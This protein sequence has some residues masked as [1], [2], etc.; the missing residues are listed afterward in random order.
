M[1]GNV[2]EHP[3]GLIA[4]A[5]LLLVVLLYGL[6][7]LVRAMQ[8]KRY[9]TRSRAP[10]ALRDR[11]VAWRLNPAY[12]RI[13][14][15]HN[16]QGFRHSTNVSLVKPPGTVRIFLLGGSAAYGAQGGFTHLENR[17]TRIYNH[18][19]IDAFLEQKLNTT[20]PSR[21]WQVINS[22]TSGYRIHQ[23]LALIQSRI[24][25]YRP[26]YVILMDGYNDFIELYNCAQAGPRAEFDIYENTPG[27]EAFDAL[28]NPQSLRSLAA[29]T[30]SW[31]R[32]TSALY[33][34]A[35]DR[36]PGAVRDPWSRYAGGHGP[37]PEP[38][39]LLDLNPEE[40]SGAV[41]ALQ[42]VSYYAHTAQQIHRILELEGI[43]PLFLLQ[44]ILIL[45]H[46]PF[47]S[48]EQKM[49]DY[50]GTLGGPLYFYLFRQIYSEIAQGMTEAAQTDG[51]FFLNLVD[52][53]D[54]TPEQAFSDFAHLTP[55]GNRVIA[56]RVFQFLHDKFAETAKVGN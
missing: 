35:Q 17:Y 3:G 16:A 8:A 51:F 46:K 5:V 36:M 50:E 7:L 2:L 6:E 22:C 47:T 33:R 44:P 37:F 43:R 53:F 26:D 19:L 1:L 49:V 48:S 41:A 40:R 24:L 13:D 15:Q 42:H 9:G 56:E 4:L 12:N 29:F 39:Q 45:S 18:Q 30:N 55:D 54:Q 10:Q 25:R 38:V 14:V 20:F 52:V 28:A 31:L 34:L 21:R 11:F 27:R 23:Q 32:A